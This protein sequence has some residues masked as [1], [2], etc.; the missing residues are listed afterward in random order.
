MV[1]VWPYPLIVKHTEGFFVDES[2]VS[3]YSVYLSQ[4]LASRLIH[5]GRG[6]EIVC[7]PK[8]DVFLDC[9]RFNLCSINAVREAW[10][11]SSDVHH[12]RF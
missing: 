1:Q 10:V 7:N 9:Y 5:V 12:L 8:A 2:E 4:C 11:V 6:G 3:A